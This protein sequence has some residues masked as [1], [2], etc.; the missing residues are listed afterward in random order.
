MALNHQDST[1]D[2][3]L[4]ELVPSR[5][6]LLFCFSCSKD[7]PVT[8]R[9]V[10]GWSFG[11]AVSVCA[12]ITPLNS[13]LSMQRRF[14]RCVGEECESQQMLAAWS[15]SR[16]GILEAFWRLSS[17]Y[18]KLRG[19]L[20]IYFFFCKFRTA[21]ECVTMD[22]FVLFLSCALKQFEGYIFRKPTKMCN[23][24]PSV[25]NDK[26]KIFRPLQGEVNR[27]VTLK[28]KYHQKQPKKRNL[29]KVSMF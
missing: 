17:S 16:P 7:K 4:W 11:C 12:T 15:C 22:L 20:S 27:I 21:M 26:Y 10:V 8:L 9:R 3:A 6:F 2:S 1:N 5:C 18:I 19:S 13:R 24:T 29:L 25:A 28:R 23:L 14:M